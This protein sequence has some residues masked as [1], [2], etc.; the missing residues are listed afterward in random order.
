[1]NEPRGVTLAPL[2]RVLAS[3]TI[4]RHIWRRYRICRPTRLYLGF[5]G[6]QHQYGQEPEL[7]RRQ[8]ETVPDNAVHCNR[9][10]LGILVILR[11]GGHGVVKGFRSQYM[12]NLPFQWR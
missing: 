6:P 2:S 4:S 1:M 7:N 8:D 9:L 12:P 10:V 11:G 3:L 5:F